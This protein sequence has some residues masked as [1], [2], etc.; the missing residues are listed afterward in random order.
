MSAGSVANSM[1]PFKYKHS[2]SGKGRFIFDMACE[3]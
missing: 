2:D 1:L 3:K